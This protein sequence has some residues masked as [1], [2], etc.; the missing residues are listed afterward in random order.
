MWN[1]MLLSWPELPSK[2]DTDF[3]PVIPGKMNK[4]RNYL[5]D[6]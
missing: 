5:M 2:R 3:Q 4:K 1:C 6:S